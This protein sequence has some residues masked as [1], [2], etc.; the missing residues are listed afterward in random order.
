MDILD[1]LGKYEY[2]Y[3]VGDYQEFK[4]E[5]SSRQAVVS[6]IEKRYRQDLWGSLYARLVEK[7][8]EY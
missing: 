3:N 2:S 7:P 8:N 4:C 6:A 1:S 5:W